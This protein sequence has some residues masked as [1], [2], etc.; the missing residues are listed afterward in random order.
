MASRK[1]PILSLA[2]TPQS[3][4]SPLLGL[5]KQRRA[6]RKPGRLRA[7][8]TR[9]Q[10]NRVGARREQNCRLGVGNAAFR[11]H[12]ILTYASRTP[13]SIFGSSVRNGTRSASSQRK[14]TIASNAGKAAIRASHRR[15]SSTG[16]MC[17]RPDCC[18]AVRAKRRQRST[19]DAPRSSPITRSL[20]PDGMIRATPNSVAFFNDVIHLLPAWERLGP[21]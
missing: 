10:G 16:G 4:I 14:A 5:V 6:S 18:A 11:T 1:I 7:Q 17:V 19:L 12:T 8:D 3:L 20:M 2:D 13:T 21:T 9:P 15:G